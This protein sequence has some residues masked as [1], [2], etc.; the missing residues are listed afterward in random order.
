MVSAMHLVVCKVIVVLNK[1]LDALSPNI[2]SWH[3]VGFLV[4]SLNGK[5]LP[6]QADREGR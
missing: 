3:A 2:L 5:L 4:T 1:H 6:L